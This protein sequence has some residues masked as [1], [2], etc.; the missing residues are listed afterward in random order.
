[1][2]R[3]T[4]G[5]FPNHNSNNPILNRKRW[6]THAVIVH[7]SHTDIYDAPTRAGI[8][9]IIDHFHSSFI[10]KRRERKNQPHRE[11]NVKCL[12]GFFRTHL[13]ELKVVD[14]ERSRWCRLYRLNLKLNRLKMFLLPLSMDNDV[15]RYTDWL[16]LTVRE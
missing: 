5:T 2:R 11:N 3:K 8:L 15:F 12:V 16:T 10:T 6:K 1:M 14:V 13:Q 7:F 9:E 4:N